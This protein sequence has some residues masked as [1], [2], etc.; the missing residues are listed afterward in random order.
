[1]LLFF[2]SQERFVKDLV[3]QERF[4]ILTTKRVPRN[5]SG[6]GCGQLTGTRVGVGRDQVNGKRS[7]FKLVFKRGKFQLCRRVSIDQRCQHI[8]HLRCR[9]RVWNKVSCK[10]QLFMHDRDFQTRHDVNHQ[11]QQP[12]ARML[13]LGM[14]DI[15]E[16]VV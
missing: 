9:E 7:G 10:T 3:G 6:F 13:L 16:R 2:A 5:R 8:T 15:T 12:G 14:L 11:V 4:V 1:M